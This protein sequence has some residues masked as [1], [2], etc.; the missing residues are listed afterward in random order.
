MGQVLSSHVCFCHKYDRLSADS[1]KGLF[2]QEIKIM[3]A[4][5]RE[6]VLK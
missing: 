5:M 1:F 4:W 6:D 3:N 2:V